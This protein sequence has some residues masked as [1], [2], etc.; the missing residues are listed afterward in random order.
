MKNK[1]RIALTLLSLIL[2]CSTAVTPAIHA[3]AATLSQYVVSKITVIPDQS[4]FEV[5]FHN[6][7]EVCPG[8]GSSAFIRL[9]K[10]DSEKAALVNL[11]KSKGNGTPIDIETSTQHNRCNIVNAWLTD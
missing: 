4:E 5:E 9:R 7:S 10:D 8:Y 6:V 11:H 2:G 1:K 3:R